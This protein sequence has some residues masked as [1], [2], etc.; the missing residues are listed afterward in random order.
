MAIDTTSVTSLVSEFRLLSAKDSV[1]PE[2]V[3]ALIQRIVDLLATANS[4]ADIKA[5]NTL[6]TNVSKFS[7]VIT[8]VNQGND[9]PN[10]V[11]V[12][13]HFADLANGT[14]GAMQDATLV[15][16]ATIA[17]AG[18]MTA[19]QVTDLSTAIADIA[20]LKANAS[21]SSGGKTYSPIQVKIIGGKPKLINYGDYKKDGMVLLL[22]RFCKKQNRNRFA[23]ENGEDPRNP[24]TKGWNMM[25]RDN[26][27]RLLKTSSVLGFNNKAHIK[28]HMNK[29]TDADFECDA[30]LLVEPHDNG[31]GDIVSW[32]KRK[33]RLD[34]AKGNPRMLR[35]RF[36]VGYAKPFDT[37]T[38]TSDVYQLVSNLAEFSV[39]YARGTDGFYWKFS[40]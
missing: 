5:L 16:A 4:D 8:A 21:T 15:P 31:E 26:S 24:V 18:A 22:Y 1:S 27:V 6:L 12:D 9:D 13:F 37:N 23:E 7:S 36:A 28:W 35:F 40:R 25:G 3:G 33:V 32:G 30:S 20:T 14:S 38:K 19:Q 10:D 39:V 29:V 11:L 17:R 34:D 2:T